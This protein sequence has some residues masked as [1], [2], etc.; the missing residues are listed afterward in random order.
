MLPLGLHPNFF[1]INYTI[2]FETACL[3]ERRGAEKKLKN[4]ADFESEIPVSRIAWVK[5]VKRKLL[6]LIYLSYFIVFFFTFVENYR[7]NED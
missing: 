1:L 2:L 4:F 5:P 3:K 6:L 7:N